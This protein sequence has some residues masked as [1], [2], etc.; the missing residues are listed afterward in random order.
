MVS[1]FPRLKHQL[2]S[3]HIN[4]SPRQFIK[5]S[6]K[7]AVF[8]SSM[9]SALAFMIIDKNNGPVLVVPVIFLGIFFVGF[10]IG[11]QMPKVKMMRR[12]NTIDQ[13]VLFAGRFLLVKLNSGQPLLNAIVDA[14]RS[15]GVGGKF[16]KEIVSDIELGTPLEEALTKSMNYTPSYKF[17]K[18]LFQITTALKIGI[19]VSGSLES[20]LEEISNQQLLEIK[21][22][23]K[24]LNGITMFYLLMAVVFPS[25]GMTLFI[26]V[27]SLLTTSKQGFGMFIAVLFFLAVLQFMFMTMFRSIR[28]KVNI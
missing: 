19:D 1:M 23:G 11:M 3:A 7:N 26:V 6:L 27:V 22:Y 20:V 12:G 24:R 16:F 10:W 17:R 5:K 2:L 28:P 21:K 25:L 13:D 18:I 14:S 9:L 15:Y 4:L 8:A